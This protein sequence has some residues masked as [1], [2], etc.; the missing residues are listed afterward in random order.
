MRSLVSVLVLLA[1][2]S[3][4][5]PPGALPEPVG[6]QLVAMPH[7]ETF[8]VYERDGVRIV[9]F[10]APVISWGGDAKGANQTARVVLV[11][12]DVEPPPL[13]GELESAVLVRTPVQ[14]IAVN[15]G[16]LEAIVNELGVADRL[17][18]VGGVKSY[19][20]DIR[21]RARKGE[22][23]QI[24]YGWHAP[25]KID[26]LVGA[27]PD[28]LF[29][30]LGDLGHAEHYA[31]I[32][33][34][35]V[36]VV[37][38]FLEAETGYMGPVDYVRLVGMFTGREDEAEAFAAMVADNVADWKARAA[39]RPKRQVLSAWFAGSGRW[40]VTVRNNENQLIEAAGGVNPM[41]QSDDTH[42]D[43]F[44]HMGSEQL[45]EEA[46][47]ADC[48]VIRDSH[49]QPFEDVAYLRHFKA[50]R[51]GNL[52]AADGSQKSEADAFAIYDTGPIRPDLKLRNLVKMLHPEIV[53]E[54]YVYIRP[55][56]KTPRR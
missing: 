42:L 19:D 4:G 9:D 22:I 7:A 51:E 5:A 29:M 36:P 2:C 27:E 12:K 46:R 50:W 47:D 1:A 54:P 11:P 10:N 32:K 41:A 17:V 20:D 21:E 8:K 39:E 53:D 48:W 56:T 15:Y 37:P 45:L 44:V 49:S 40:M 14:R 33:G 52:F 13:T 24:G 38:V 26:T 6:A 43:H 25:P 31:R 35:G 18:A 34:L 30:V 55:D 28:V 3:P 23:A 16:F